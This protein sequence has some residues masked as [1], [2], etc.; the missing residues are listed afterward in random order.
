MHE[1]PVDFQLKFFLY[2]GASFVPFIRGISFNLYKKYLLP[3]GILAL[4]AG[5]LAFVLIP[6]TPNY[7]SL[8][9]L[10]PLFSIALMELSDHL[11]ENL[12]G[13]KIFEADINSWDL[14]KNPFWMG[15]YETIVLISSFAVPGLIWLFS[16]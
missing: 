16:S 7:L 2:L 5:I 11:Y 9:L 1:L 6:F 3:W 12:T 10:S 15:L 13:Q 8:C 4:I 14:E